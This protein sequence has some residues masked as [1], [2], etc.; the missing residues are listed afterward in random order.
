MINLSY[1][2]VIIV[3]LFKINIE[4]LINEHKDF[5]WCNLI[6]IFLDDKVKKSQSYNKSVY[7]YNSQL[8]NLLIH[9]FINC[10]NNVSNKK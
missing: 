10:T 3:L 1:C 7:F 4:N 9:L 8:I 5:Y 6:L 2:F